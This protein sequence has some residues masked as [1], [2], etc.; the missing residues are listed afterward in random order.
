VAPQASTTL[1]LRLEAS[2]ALALGGGE[3]APAAPILPAPFRPPQTG[4][5][6]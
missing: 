2:T 5:V 4:R 3:R 1:V 6:S